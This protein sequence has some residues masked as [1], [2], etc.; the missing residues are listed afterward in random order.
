MSDL[1]GSSLLKHVLSNRGGEL[2]F[3][4]VPGL[5]S[6]VQLDGTDEAGCLQ[7]VLSGTPEPFCKLGF[8]DDTAVAVLR[9]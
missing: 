6:H 8:L 3:F 7:Q 2:F 1:K 4:G 5:S 9:R